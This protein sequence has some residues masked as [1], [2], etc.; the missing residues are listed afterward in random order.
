VI[1][2]ALQ[3][4][5]SVEAN[6]AALYLQ[7]QIALGAYWQVIAGVRFDRFELDYDNHL[8]VDF[9]REDEMVSPRLG[10]I[11][12]PIEPLSLY[13]SYSVS[14]LPQ[15]GDQFSSLNA[16]TSSLEPEEFENIELG[17]KWDLS[18]RL[19]LTAAIYRL[20]RSNTRATDPDTL[21]T[22][23]TGAQRSEG[24]ELG[25]SG[26]INA[27]W[28][29][30]GGYSYQNVEITR[31][32]TAAPAGRVVPLTPEHTFSLWNMV[33]ATPRLGLGVG[34]VHQGESFASI[35]NNVVLPEFTRVDA[36]V[37]YAL[38][39]SVE[40]QLNIENLF[41]EEYWATAHSDNNIMPASPTAARFTLR[42]RF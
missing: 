39:D 12:R 28:D 9:S 2:A 10:V 26:S 36:A 6:V 30:V 5:N 27:R 17:A 7:D 24:F 35:S 4:D 29:I 25:L 13:A 15:S 11:Y 19:A 18:E 37:T 40:A 32:T 3:T 42:T 8:G 1:P 34:V 41:D 31:T 33:Q 14:Y 38:T 23:L 16:D 20:D 22:V 21:A